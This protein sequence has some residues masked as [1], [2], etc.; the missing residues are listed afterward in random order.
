MKSSQV[1]KELRS[2]REAWRKQSFSYSR[3][4]QERYDHLVKLRRER[5]SSLYAEERVSKGSPK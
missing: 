5:V 4:Q 1:L 2:L 3:E